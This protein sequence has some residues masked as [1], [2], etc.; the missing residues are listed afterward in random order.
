[1]QQENNQ[2]TSSRRV[3]M[4]DINALL[5]APISRIKTLRGDEGRSGF[6]ARFV[7]PTLRAA[8]HAGYSGRTGFTLIELLVVV[9]IIGIL[10]AVALPQYQ[11]AVWKARLTPVLTF[12]SNVEKAGQ[13]YAL[14][15]GYPPKEESIPL[16]GVNSPLA[17]DL[18]PP[19]LPVMNTGTVKMIISPIMQRYTTMKEI[20][21]SNG[22][23]TSKKTSQI[24]IGLLLFMQMELLII[25][26]LTPSLTGKQCV[27]C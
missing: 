2:L 19:P 1:M 6:T 24:H 21:N 14:E 7:T 4:R 27:S 5:S 12:I 18:F 3:G 10:A 9:L 26:V 23:F 13:V 22:Q 16:L 17:L 8:I 25:T 11:K 20:L 15:H